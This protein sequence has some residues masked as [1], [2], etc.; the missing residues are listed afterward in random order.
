MSLRNAEVE[1]VHYKTHAIGHAT[2]RLIHDFAQYSGIVG[3]K[4]WPGMRFQLLSL[5]RDHIPYRVTWR[6]EG[7]EI[8]FTGF[9]DPRPTIREGKLV[10]ESPE[11]RCAF[12]EQPGE[13]SPP[14]RTHIDRVTS[15]IAQEMETVYRLRIDRNPLALRFPKTLYSDKIERFKIPILDSIPTGVPQAFHDAFK[16]SSGWNL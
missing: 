8:E 5:I 7:I 15:A 2:G 11:P 9:L 13:V 14:V 16:E 3:T 4:H 6:A 1:V 12:F 10:Y